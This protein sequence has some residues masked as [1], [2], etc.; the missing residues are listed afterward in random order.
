M[1]L[2]T[3]WSKFLYYLSCQFLKN[4]KESTNFLDQ[5]QELHSMNHEW[6]TCQS[7][8]FNKIDPFFGK[9]FRQFLHETKNQF[10]VR[11]LF[12]LLLLDKKDKEQ[13]VIIEKKINEF[14]FIVFEQG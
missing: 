6:L 5:V 13:I 4:K 7:V 8:S 12:L 14:T 2:K 9:Y 3:I 1:V 11:K 10:P